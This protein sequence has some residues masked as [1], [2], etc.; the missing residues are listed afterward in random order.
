[1]GSLVEYELDGRVGIITLRG[2][3]VN[4][5]TVALLDE[6]RA[7]QDALA[8]AEVSV[9][10]VR[11]AVPD[12]FVAGADLKLLGESSVEG[13][14]GYLAHARSTIERLAG[15]EYLTIAGIDGHAL[16]GGLE[17]ALACSLRVAGPGAKLGV[18]EIKLGIIPG[19]G[20]T[21]RLARI[22]P[23]GK[24]LDLILTGR[25]VDAEEAYSLGIV[26]RLAPEGQTGAEAALEFAHQLAEGPTEAYR[27]TIRAADAARDMSFDAGMEVEREEVLRLFGSADGRE[28]VAA[29]LEKRRP[30]FGGSS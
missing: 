10:V 14:D 2:P 6:L 5:L 26:E 15:R 19:A 29:F 23:R 22:L 3:P 20:G 27:S 17:L 8:A 30:G 9:A 28:G 12:F 1:M 24:A 16:G 25:S 21:Q 4:A 18:P 13:F 7:A 11:S